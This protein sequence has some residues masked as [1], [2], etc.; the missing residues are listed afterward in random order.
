MRSISV[1]LFLVAGLSSTSAPLKPKEV[2]RDG[3][4]PYP[5]RAI[6]CHPPVVMP[7]LWPGIPSLR[8][9]AEAKTWMAGHQREDALRASARP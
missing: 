3:T 1:C 2:D 5:H 4:P 8:L 7:G 6:D 9:F